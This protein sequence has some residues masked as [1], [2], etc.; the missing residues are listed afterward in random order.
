M[1]RKIVEL[2]LQGKT[3]REV[4]RQLGIGDRRVRKVRSALATIRTVSRIT[5]V[6]ENRRRKIRRHR[7]LQRKRP[8]G[9]ARSL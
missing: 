7:S 6:R 5:L 8:C 2:F 1:D 4:M 9:K 3:G